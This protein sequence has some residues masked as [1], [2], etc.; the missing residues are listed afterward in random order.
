MATRRAFLK[1]GGL[2]LAGLAVPRPVRAAAP[3][4]IGMMSDKLG[5]K[6]W[7]DP[8]GLLVEPGQTI[9]WIVHS[10]VHTTTAYHPRNDHHSLRIPERAA[11]WDSRFLVNP[12]HHFEVRL[13]VPGVYDYFC[14]PHEIAGMVGRIVVGRPEGP[15]TLPFD[16][17]RGRPGTGQWKPVPKAAQAAFPSVSTIVRQR[18]V[19]R[20]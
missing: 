11:P 8:I 10:N 9:R 6:V 2:A 1:A 4:E 18:V 12:G 16:Y 13:T 14:A 15:G 20:A 3:V 7:F 17:F 19:R 5:T